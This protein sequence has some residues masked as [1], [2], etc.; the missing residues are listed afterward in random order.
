MKKDAMSGS[1]NG[2]RFFV[3]GDLPI[4]PWRH[5]AALQ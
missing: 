3:I 2:A 5:I 1:L 4:D